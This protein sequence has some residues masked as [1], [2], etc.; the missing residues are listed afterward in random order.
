MK[1]GVL[2]QKLVLGTTR[3]NSFQVLRAPTNLN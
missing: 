1:D 2:S 3:M